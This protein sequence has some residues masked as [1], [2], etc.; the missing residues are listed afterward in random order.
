MRVVD[1]ASR[2]VLPLKV[3]DR[4]LVRLRLGLEEEGEVGC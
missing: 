1:N 2:S 4:G 3:E